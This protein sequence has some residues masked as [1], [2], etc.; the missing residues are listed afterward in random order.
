MKHICFYLILTA[1]AA[2]WYIFCTS[3]SF[4]LDQ[5]MATICSTTAAL[6]GTMFGLSAASYA[7]VCGELSGEERNS[8]HL[9]CVL[10]IYRGELW[11]LF[12]TSLVLMLFTVITSL[13]SIGVAQHL[14]PS[15]PLNGDGAVLASCANRNV[16]CLSTL[17]FANLCLT[18]IALFVMSKLNCMIFQRQIRYSKLAQDIMKDAVA[19][20]KRPEG[21]KPP[22][23]GP[24]RD[25]LEK[26]RNLER[27]VERVL[28]NH[29]S[30]QDTFVPERHLEGLL[31]AVLAQKLREEYVDLDSDDEKALI[32][33]ECEPFG[34]LSSEKN[35]SRYHQCWR[36][37]YQDYT[38][39]PQAG[40]QDGD[41]ETKREPR[42]CCFVKVYCDLIRYRD[43]RLVYMNRREKSDEPAEVDGLYLRWSVKR[44]LLV[45]LLQGES[46]SNMDLTRVCLSGAD[47]RH[48]NLSNSNL[49]GARL[50]GANCEGA[51]FSKARLSGMF[52]EDSEAGCTGQI[53]VSCKDDHKD[54][55][56]PYHGEEATCFREATFT[57]ADAS[58]AFLA[59]ETPEPWAN[60]DSHFPI[61][62]AER[63]RERPKLYSF[64]GTS[65]DYTKLYS[66]RFRDL[67]FD[68][69]SMEFSLIFDAAFCRCQA[70]STNFRGAVLTR[71]CLFWC[72]FN[73]AN[74]TSAVF[75]Q[76]ILLRCS[77][78]GARLEGAS[79]T[80]ANLVLCSFYGSSCQNV[81]F[82]GIVQDIKHIEERKLDFSLFMRSGL[83]EHHKSEGD[84]QVWPVRLDFRFATLSNTDFSGADIS[85]ACFD[86]AVGSDCVF[87]RASGGNVQMTDTFLA[88]S[89]FN[90]CRFT[91]STFQRTMLRDSVFV[92][93]QF[94]DCTIVDTDFSN[95]LFDTG[96]TP[97]FA[98][99]TI[100]QRARFNGT[101]GLTAACF[102]KTVVCEC[103]FRNTE[104]REDELRRVCAKVVDCTFGAAKEVG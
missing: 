3:K 39:L 76:A 63:P 52:F 80:E 81:S 36:Q 2:L 72:D 38:Q 40:G 104:V 73:S 83:D 7:F 69:A 9:K 74:M 8:P 89:I 75:A 32:D 34:F 19:G 60:W 87:T 12:M 31:S 62:E 41:R 17:V 14:A 5:H 16:R 59:A 20:Y 55:W 88:S 15:D 13:V 45:F 22:P 101:V 95:A 54:K 6:V 48:A 10:A 42:E 65:F 18:V 30:V 21:V 27:I 1:A 35:R 90:S 50:L 94:S 103:D 99:K 46:L 23:D 98:N 96:G 97:C 53:A 57:H 44:R 43:S 47:L 100:I 61:L 91:G 77:F 85:Y 24:P 58:G 56:N 93:A 51:D 33:T 70:R 84:K 68:H 66:S 92:Q 82:R 78:S 37:A 11:S 71:S 28:Q 26:I 79:F 67:S 49:S 4:P 86:H 64:E 25:E 102:S 29:E